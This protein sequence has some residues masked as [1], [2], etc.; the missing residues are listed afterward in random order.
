MS[1]HTNRRARPLPQLPEGSERMYELASLGLPADLVLR[2]E[3][4]LGLRGAA[5]L[6]VVL[7]GDGLL[8]ARTVSEGE[9]E[10][11]AALL[12]TIRRLGARE[13]TRVTVVSGRDR[14]T[15]ERWFRPTGASCYA[16][17]G[18]WRSQRPWRWDRRI[19]FDA[20]WHARVGTALASIARTQ[21]RTLFES[22]VDSAA[23]L[24]CV[25]D[26]AARA[27]WREEVRARV[28][29]LVRSEGARVEYLRDSVVVRPGSNEKR[30][31]VLDAIA[32]RRPDEEL[33]VVGHERS[34]HEMLLAALRHGVAMQVGLRPSRIPWTLDDPPTLRRMLETLACP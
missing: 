11:D 23:L 34:E 13:G 31:A 18:A 28:E 14:S 25:F 15:V 8:G 21:R 9:A 16:E 4:I 30:V 24:C 29:P 22:R 33:L 10:P 32:E 27:R 6:H 3:L 12:A 20:A 7:G 19:D 26:D 2:P 5:R 1:A 17:H